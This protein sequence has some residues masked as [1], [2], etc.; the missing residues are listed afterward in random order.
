M[1]P[2]HGLRRAGA[3]VLLVWMGSTLFWDTVHT[4]HEVT[5]DQKQIDWFEDLV[6]VRRT[7][8]DVPMHSRGSCSNLD[9]ILKL[10]FKLIVPKLG[11]CSQAL[12]LLQ[13]SCS[14]RRARCTPPRTGGRC[15]SSPTPRPTAPACASCRRTTLSTSATGSTTP[16]RPSARSSSNWSGSIAASR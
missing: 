8:R 15:S 1:R 5:I 10:G 12:L 14:D 11:R 3:E 16:T 4:S 7:E 6:Q 9:V 13:N 2:R